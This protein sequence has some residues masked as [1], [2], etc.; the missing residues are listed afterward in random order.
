M[1]AIEIL[2]LG[3]EGQPHGA[4]AGF[5]DALDGAAPTG[6]EGGD[7]AALAIGNQHGNAIGGLDGEEEA[8]V[9]GELSVGLARARAGCVGVDGVDDAVG[10]ELAESDQRD[11]GIGC[12]GLGKE[13]AIAPNDRAV[14]GFGEAE[15][16]FGGCAFG[17]VG[18]AEAAFAGGETCPEPGKV[19]AGD[20][21]P[22]DTI[23][24]AAGDGGGSG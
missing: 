9:V 4:D 12:D 18:A 16:E 3:A 6:V 17:A 10:M 1:A 13:A 21:K 8:G 5:N 14:V 11:F 7:D 22:L 2:G 23:S 20:R 15:V 24:G 19:P